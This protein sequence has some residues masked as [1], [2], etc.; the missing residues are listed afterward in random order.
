MQEGHALQLDV[1]IVHALGMGTAMH[2]AAGARPRR[3]RRPQSPCRTSMKTCHDLGGHQGTS[4][5]GEAAVTGAG[6]LVMMTAELSVILT[7]HLPGEEGRL[8]GW[9]QHP[10]VHPTPRLA[11]GSTRWAWG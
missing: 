8:G 10:T 11:P 4:T 5:D 1:H 9:G 3:G 6:G 7:V 2:K